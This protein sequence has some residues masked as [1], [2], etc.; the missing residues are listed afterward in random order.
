MKALIIEDEHATALRLKK[1]LEELEP[2]II[3]PAILDTV[4][5]SVRWFSENMPPDIVFMDI[6]LADGS[7][8]GIFD[9]VKVKA[10][11]VFITAYDTYALRAFRVNSIDYLLKPVKKSELKASLEKFR[12]YHASGTAA[13]PD[14]EALARILRK[15]EYQ[16]R[17]VVRYGQKIKAIESED[18]AYFFTESGNAFFRTFDNS[19]YPA[20]TSLDKL[21]G[22]L[23]PKKFYRI[24]RQFIIN[25]NAIRE[26]FNYSKSRVKIELTPPCEYDSIASA[27]RS[28]D[29]KK[30]LSGKS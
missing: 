29:F 26:M 30:W 25:V 18:I 12:E 3:I 11:V 15:E 27:E 20:E 9:R 17:F 6:H 19:T 23:D 22:L 21:E 4:D 2:G 24:N 8:F 5:S 10:P 28:G 13:L 16:K 7:A 14:F 1:I